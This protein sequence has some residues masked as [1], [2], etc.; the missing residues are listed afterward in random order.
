M[1]DEFALG[2]V[3]AAAE[4]AA[5][6]DS[7]DV[8]ARYVQKRFGAVSVSFLFLDFVGQE[9]VRLAAADDAGAAWNQPG[10]HPLA[11]QRPPTGSP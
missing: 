6:M 4:D 11:G 3:L 5:P 2:E 9:L 1:A 8:V 7:V 10:S